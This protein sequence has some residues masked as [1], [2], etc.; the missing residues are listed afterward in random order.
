MKKVLGIIASPRRL[1]NCEIV[2]KEI[3]RSIPEPH[4][5]H[6]LRLSDFHIKPCK[7][8]YLC[9]FKKERCVLKDDLYDILDAVYEAEAYILAVPTYFLGPNASLK[10]LI[11][12]GL[13]FYAFAE[14]MWGKP[15]VGVGIA[16]IQNKE[17]YTLL[18][19]E[20]FLKLILS[21]IR[22]VNIAYGALP[23]EVFLNEE[24]RRMASEMGR[25]LFAASDRKN[26]RQG[27][28]VPSCP[29][30]G[31]STF[32]FVGFNKVRC[33]V[34]S[35]SGILQHENGAAQLRITKDA[36]GLFLALEDVLDHKKWLQDQVRRY[37]QQR[38]R[39]KTVTTDYKDDGQWMKPKRNNSKT[40]T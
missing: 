26:E 17:G 38:D 6:L 14:K 4:E 31:G 13:A 21:D 16:G 33:M 7:A 23:G 1:G 36:H 15:S 28:S 8:C 39:L 19:I 30:C 12:R 25:A 20:S 18:G 32:R 9:L 10:R 27:K 37:V 29:L 5:L 24:N 2:V 40:K 22:A 35:Q 34:C 3:G 11:D